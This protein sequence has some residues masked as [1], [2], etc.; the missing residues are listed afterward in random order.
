M[1]ESEQL[2][3]QG[4]P[5]LNESL[6]AKGQHRFEAV[7]APPT[8]RR[9]ILA[10]KPQL[11]DPTGGHLLGRGRLPTDYAHRRFVDKSARR[12]RPRDPINFMAVN[13]SNRRD[14]Q[15]TNREHFN[16]LRDE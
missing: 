11:E 4:L 5:V 13:N 9:L 6:K 2:L 16:T 12:R 10:V 14:R 15:R 8:R 1:K 7:P 3:A